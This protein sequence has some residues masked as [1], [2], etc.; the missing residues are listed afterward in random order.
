MV[1]EK[2]NTIHDSIQG[3]QLY[4]I[5]QWQSYRSCTHN[6]LDVKPE[7]NP[8]LNIFVFTCLYSTLIILQCTD[9]LDCCSG[10]CHNGVC[11]NPGLRKRCRQ[12]GDRV[13]VIVH[14]LLGNN[15]AMHPAGDA[16]D[17]KK[18]LDN[19]LITL[20]NNELKKHNKSIISGK[21]VV[22]IYPLKC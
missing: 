6:C 17:V 3:Q 21:P 10:V 13:S 9:R 8:D 5:D 18:Y 11:R 15:S 22:L 20:T 4:V 16:G 2:D 19:L 7:K 12:Q 14:S 1:V